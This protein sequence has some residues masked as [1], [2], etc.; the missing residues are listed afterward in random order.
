MLKDLKI[1]DIINDIS[2]AL[3]LKHE[4]YKDQELPTETDILL[5]QVRISVF[6]QPYF[7]RYYVIRLY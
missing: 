1:I 3:F 6:L 7:Y 5:K 2:G 4:I